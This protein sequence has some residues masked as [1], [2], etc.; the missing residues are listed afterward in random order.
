MLLGCLEEAAQQP[1]LLAAKAQLF[2]EGTTPAVT[3]SNSL[4][5]GFLASQVSNSR[6]YFH[7]GPGAGYF[8]WWP[9]RRPVTGANM[10]LQLHEGLL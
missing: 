3:V 4:L 7:P 5:P 10:L 6:S 9:R 1:Q 8:L 2:P